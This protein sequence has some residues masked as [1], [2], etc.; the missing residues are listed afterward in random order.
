MYTHMMV[1]MMMQMFVL[2]SCHNI[3]LQYDVIVFEKF[4]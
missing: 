3:K 2:H 4:I 1:M